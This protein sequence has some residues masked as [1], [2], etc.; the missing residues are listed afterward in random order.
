MSYDYTSLGANL[1]EEAEKYTRS[2]A[3]S[4]CAG[5]SVR[6]L[7]SDSVQ[8]EYYLVD[9]ADG[10]LLGLSLMALIDEGLLSCDDLVTDILPGELLPEMRD[11]TVRRLMRRVSG[12]PDP[13]H[14][15]LLPELY[16]DPAFALLSEEEKA[17]RGR[18]AM[19]EHRSLERQMALL[20]SGKSILRLRRAPS[21]LDAAIL[22]RAAERLIP[23]G[24]MNFQRERLLAPLGITSLACQS[25]YEEKKIHALTLEQLERL[26]GALAGGEV[27]LSAECRAL[28]ASAGGKHSLPFFADRNVLCGHSE[29]LGHT[30]EIFFDTAAGV[31]VLSASRRPPAVTRHGE[32][33]FRL[34][35]DILYHM[36]AMG[37]FPRQPCLEPMNGQHFRDLACMRLENEQ[38]DYV[39]S[40]VMLIAENVIQEYRDAKTVYM[41]TDSGTAVGALA[42]KRG[43]GAGRFVLDTLLI[44]RRFQRRGF[45]KAA[46][47]LVTDMLKGMD[48][49]ELTVCVSPSNTAALKLYESHG[50]ELA[51]VYSDCLALRKML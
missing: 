26:A 51:A 50:F 2:T 14:G 29:A 12:L 46:L 18:A 27:Q 39:S 45:G 3:L 38:R 7:C 30:V 13:L 23:D 33:F 37:I 1:I 36:N 44:D 6:R 43:V 5:G 48:G 21:C 19:L 9:G 31:S 41:I 15:V 34:D 17:K 22:T 8:G 40:P 49:R 35:V 20:H 42:V 47:R 24:L 10:M 25:E 4:L 32:C 28:S 16:S 11:P